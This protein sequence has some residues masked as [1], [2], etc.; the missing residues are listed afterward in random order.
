MREALKR[1][2]TRDAMEREWMDK[3]GVLSKGRTGL[4]EDNDSDDGGDSG[5][6]TS[7]GENKP[8]EVSNNLEI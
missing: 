1:A 5:N 3:K 8:T 2:K 7:G 4:Q 6:D